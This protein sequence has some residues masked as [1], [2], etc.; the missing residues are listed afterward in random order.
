M[1]ATQTDEMLKTNTVEA[2]TCSTEV[3]DKS[4]ETL[5]MHLDLDSDTE[6]LFSGFCKEMLKQLGKNDLGKS[7]LRLLVY[8]GDEDD[9]IATSDYYA[10][11]AKALDIMIDETNE[12][13]GDE[14]T[15]ND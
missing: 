12:D 11:Y 10:D 7:H 14:E 2:Q 8:K 13:I 3:E 4:T 6:H 9:V 5:L 15:Q 1:K